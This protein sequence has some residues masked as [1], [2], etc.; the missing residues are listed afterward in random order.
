MLTEKTLF[1]EWFEM[2]QGL[3]G[4]LDESRGGIFNGWATPLLDF[5]TSITFAKAQNAERARSGGAD[6]GLARIWY[7]RSD[8]AFY[9]FEDDYAADDDE[10]E[11]TAQ[12][13]GRIRVCAASCNRSWSEQRIVLLHRAVQSEL[14]R[15]A[16]EKGFELP[17]PGGLHPPR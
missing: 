17:E 1:F 4:W 8:D 14:E 13:A 6:N 7:R 11:P 3:K 9:V 16:K 2:P 12:S 15:R 10:Y 5:E